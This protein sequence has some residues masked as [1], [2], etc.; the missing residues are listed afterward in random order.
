M[1]GTDNTTNL[2]KDVNWQFTMGDARIKFGRLNS[3]I[4]QSKATEVLAVA[5][6]HRIVV[7]FIEAKI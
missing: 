2:R 4:L 1:P 3:L 5:T 6:H 7:Y